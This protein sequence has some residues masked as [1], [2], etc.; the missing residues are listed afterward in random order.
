LEAM[1]KKLPPVMLWQADNC[2]DNKNKEVF[3]FASLLVERKDFKEI[4]LNFLIVVC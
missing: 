1:G 4:N 2:G 3:A